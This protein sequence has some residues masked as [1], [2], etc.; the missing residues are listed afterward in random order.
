MSFILHYS[1]HMVKM[2]VIKIFLFLSDYFIRD[3]AYVISEFCFLSNGWVYEDRDP[4]WQGLVSHY[5][6]IDDKGEKYTDDELDERNRV[7]QEKI[8][9]WKRQTG[10]KDQG[11]RLRRSEASPPHIGA[12]GPTC[13]IKGKANCSRSE[14]NQE[15]RLIRSKCEPSP[16]AVS[17]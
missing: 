10:P 3:I 15:F 12:S 13:L 2:E 7:A 5:Y 6:Y 14:S 9:C 8:R 1:P 11:L 4:E 16:R 17:E